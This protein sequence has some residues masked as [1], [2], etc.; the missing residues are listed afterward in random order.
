MCVE[1]AYTLCVSKLRDLREVLTHSLVFKTKGILEQSF[2]TSLLQS[3]LELVITALALKG[4][5]I[6][7]FSLA[8][9]E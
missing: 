4:K 1:N 3:D 7:A 9:Y 5:T 8:N 2:S 6:Q